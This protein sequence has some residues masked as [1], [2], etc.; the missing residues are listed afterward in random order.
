MNKSKS[1]E[2]LKDVLFFTVFQ[3][4]VVGV[5]GVIVCVLNCL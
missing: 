1:V 4:L 2:V 3:V 5:V